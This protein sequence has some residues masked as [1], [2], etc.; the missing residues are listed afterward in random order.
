MDFVVRLSAASDYL[1][2]VVCTSVDD[3]ATAGDDY[4]GEIGTLDF[5]PAQTSG[6]ITIPIFDDA[7][8]EMD[9]NGST[10]C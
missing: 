5:A 10:W 7:L 3:T 1:V 2:S 8:D 9:R 4:E 6:T